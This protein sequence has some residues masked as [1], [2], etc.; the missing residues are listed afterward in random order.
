VPPNDTKKVRLINW[1]LPMKRVLYSLV[2][3]IL[4]SIYFFGWRAFVLLVIANGVAFICEY[5]F[6]KQYNQPVSS[7]VFVTGCLFAL[8]LPPALPYWIAVVGVVFAVVFGKMVFGGFGKNIFNPALTG[9]AFIYI[10]FGDFMTARGWYRP[11][12]GFPG[13]FAAYSRM[14]DLDATTSAT[15]GSWLV[16]SAE[17]L[18]EAGVSPGEFTWLRLFL[19]NTTGVIGGTSAVLVLAGIAYLLY[20]KTANYRIVA[21]AIVGYLLMQAILHY[22]GF[23]AAHP[24][25]GLFAGSVIFA[26]CYYATD[27]V[28]AAKTQEGRWI[29]GAFIGLIYP[30]ITVF[31]IWP[32][33]AQFSILLANMFSPIL[34]YTI[35]SVKQKNKQKGA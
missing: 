4:S 20:T 10:S 25:N 34:D 30:V 16:Y 8:G 13:G 33:G 6:C 23:E 18:A 35:R 21:S 15:P 31:S 3:I 24:V 26:V 7:A 19:G 14:G 5:A 17:R 27:P 1:Q 28:S 11:F 9:R 22:T 12:S 2:P 29:Y 32:A